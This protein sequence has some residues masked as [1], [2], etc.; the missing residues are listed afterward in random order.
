MHHI[1]NI[2]FLAPTVCRYFQ[3]RGFGGAELQVIQ[4]A[5]TFVQAGH[6]VSILT[7]DP[8]MQ[9]QEEHN[10]IL[11]IKTPLRF[12][13]GSNWYFLPDTLRFIRNFGKYDFDYCFLKNPNTA[14][15]QLAAAGCF[16]KKVKVYKIFASNGDSFPKYGI[17]DLLYRIGLRLADGVIFQTA[18]QQKEAGENLGIY[19][20][21]ISNIFSPPSAQELSDDNEIDVL[22]IG[23]FQ[24]NKRPEYIY[25]IAAKMPHIRFTVI[26]KPITI[27]EYR[28]LA[29]KLRQLPN[30][31]F[32]GTVP[33]EQTQSYFDRAKIFLCT[34]KVEGF[35]NTFLQSWYA[36]H[37]VV[38]ITFPCDGILER[39]RCGMLSGSIEQAI[40][41]IDGLLNDKSLL[42]TMGNNGFNYLCHNHLADKILLMYQDLILSPT[43]SGSDNLLQKK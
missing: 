18:A 20:P 12:L 4:L 41:D 3:G 16:C 34:S 26:S 31:N 7:Y 42:E 43:S 23:A 29:D 28:P 24:H 11:L 10:G 8:E 39:E 9:D 19:G 13:G 25:E 17:T 40:L 37:P 5:R 36:K 32:I 6:R 38:S 30:V 1:R 33:F 27:E 14:L 15:F 21:V 22:W 35:P 2:G